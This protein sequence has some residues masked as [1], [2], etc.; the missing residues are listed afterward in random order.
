ML[1]K[2]CI[3]TSA[4]ELFQSVLREDVLRMSKFVFNFGLEFRLI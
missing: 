2:L 4:P 3:K 1:S